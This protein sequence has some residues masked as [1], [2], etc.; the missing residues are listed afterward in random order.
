MA[1]K[2]LWVAIKNPWVAIQF[3]VVAIKTGGDS[4]AIRWP[5]GGD[6]VATG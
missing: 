6:S 1:I 5:L 4:V 2:F 3:L